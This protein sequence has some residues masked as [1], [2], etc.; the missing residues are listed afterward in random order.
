[1]GRKRSKPAPRKKETHRVG[2][3]IRVR[4]VRVIDADGS[5]LG[6]LATQDA[7]RR[8]D[9]Q[10]LE[11][12]EVNPKASPPVCKIM[13]YGKFKYENAKRERDAKKNKKS[14]ELKEVKFRP[15]TH[16]HDFTFKVKH[17]RRFLEDNN[18]VRLLVQFRGREV[19][20]PETGRDVLNR[21]I[22]EVM[23]LATVIQVP[24]MEGNRMSMILAPKARRDVNAK[25]APVIERAPAPERST[26]R[27]RAAGES[28]PTGPRPTSDDTGAP[29]PA[30]DQDEAAEPSAETAPV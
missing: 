14:Q 29:E 19:V 20:H 1:M 13:D 11:L 26:R 6:I 25:P 15:K 16:D 5:S 28:K 7:M 12:V 23:D 8:A 4:E 22:K 27:T 18:K 21:V 17:A 24:S 3:R 9:E 30:A 10:S 2:R